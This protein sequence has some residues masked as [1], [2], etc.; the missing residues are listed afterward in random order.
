MSK[1]PE[2]LRP[3]YDFSAGVDVA[4]LLL[5]DRGLRLRRAAAATVVVADEDARAVRQCEQALDRVV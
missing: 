4:R 5:G 2:E 3:E 1:E